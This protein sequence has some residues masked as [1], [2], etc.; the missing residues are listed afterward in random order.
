MDGI[1]VSVAEG[2]MTDP[3]PISL[4]LD[5]EAFPIPGPG[6]YQWTKNGQNVTSNDRITYNYPTV[7]FGNVRR[8]DA[9]TYELY[10]AN[11]KV[12]SDGTT[13][14]IGNDTGSFTLDVLC[15]CGVTS[16]A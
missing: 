15:E 10:A 9:G 8:E 11:Y 13:I 4:Q 16:Q 1:V 2:E 3:D 12:L 14:Q 6:Q 5:P 7:S